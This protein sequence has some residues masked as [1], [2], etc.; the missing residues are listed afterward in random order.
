MA[1]IT[2]VWDYELKQKVFRLNG[3]KGYLHK[4]QTSFKKTGTHNKSVLSH[5]TAQFKVNVNH[6]IE[7]SYI[8]IYDNS[9]PIPFSIG[10]VE[11]TQYAWTDNTTEKTV[12]VKLGYNVEHNLKA[13]YMGNP[14]GLSSTSRPIK[15]FES[16]PDI[17][18][19]SLSRT[20]DTTQF[21]TNTNIEIPIQFVSGQ[22]A[23]SAVTKEVKFYDNDVYKG[24]IDLHL[25]AG[26]NTATGTVVFSSLN[27]GAHNLYFVFE[28]D[29]ENEY[30][31]LTSKINV[32]YNIE[33]ID[34]PHS[35]VY[36]NSNLYDDW[37]TIKVRVRSWSG[38][39]QNGVTVNATGVNNLS[40]T[41]NSEG[42]AT[43]VEDEVNNFVATY[44]NSSSKSLK[45]PCLKVANITNSIS[46]SYFTKGSDN[47]ISTDI[48]SSSWT[49][50]TG[51]FT[52]IP[53]YVSDAN[54]TYVGKL[55][56][57][58][59][60]TVNYTNSSETSVTLTSQIGNATITNTF[61]TLL[62]Y[63]NIIDSIE[64]NRQYYTIAG[65][66]LDLATGCKLKSDSNREFSMGFGDGSTEMGSYEIVFDNLTEVKRVILECGG[67][68][69]RNG[70]ITWEFPG[71]HKEITL[72]RGRYRLIRV[73]GTQLVAFFNDKQIFS[74]QMSSIGEPA[75]RLRFKG[76]L[77]STT[78]N[79]VK[80]K[81]L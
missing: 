5:F 49:F 50:G 68:R 81:K 20:T 9:L 58:G 69:R 40:A 71:Y 17:F 56:E 24:T 67:W 73:R 23:S 46:P 51:K 6:D 28:G 4:T 77:D 30:S 11:Y 44:Q 38:S 54:H 42:I 29:D 72:E 59:E 41:T 60:A 70:V 43:F 61:E 26:S 15:L 8:V 25:A 64:L 36:C 27:N 76:S 19:S 12:T 10:G 32:G 79:N 53:V 47:V 16:T 74:S 66:V 34:Y 37:N 48:T 2:T 13:R 75:L 57:S 80:I 63:W 31:T 14:F 18:I 52:N 78:I 35:T 65:S 62:Q 21:D 1:N 3:E 45:L 39:P 33:F 55:D 7:N 22:P